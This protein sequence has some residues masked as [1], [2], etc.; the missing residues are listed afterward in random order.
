MFEPI[1]PCLLKH[2]LAVFGRNYQEGEDVNG[3]EFGTQSKRTFAQMW[4]LAE[5]ELL[6]SMLS[7][8]SYLL[9]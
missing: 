3:E 8:T 4:V 5:S 2:C 9:L 6:N 1:Y 7:I